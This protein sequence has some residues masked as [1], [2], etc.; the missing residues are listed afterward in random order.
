MSEQEKTYNVNMLKLVR[1]G[2]TALADAQAEKRSLQNPVSETHF[3]GNWIITALK[4]KRFDI[5]LAGDLKLWLQESRTLGKNAN[6][7]QRFEKIERV[8]TQ[9]CELE[10]KN[11]TQFVLEDILT[12]LDNEGWLIETESKV[13]DKFKLSSSGE[14]SLVICAEVYDR[15]FSDTDGVLESPL[16]VFIRHGDLAFIDKM[17]S[18]G[19]LVFGSTNRSIV[20]RHNRYILRPFNHAKKLAILPTLAD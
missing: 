13:T 4:E 2:L 14:N 3:L 19:Y 8:Y 10:Y 11:L 15:A 6:F 1:E 5:I 20:K 7:K 17:Y 12:E 18:H 9:I 16:S